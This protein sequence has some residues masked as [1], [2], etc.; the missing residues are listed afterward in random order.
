MFCFAYVCLLRVFSSRTMDMTGVKFN[1]T[2]TW[3]V[4]PLEQITSFGWYYMSHLCINQKNWLVCWAQRWEFRGMLFKCFH[5][6]SQ[7][8]RARHA[9]YRAER[10]FQFHVFACQC[11][12]LSRAGN[13]GLR[14]SLFTCRDSGRSCS[15]ARRSLSFKRTQLL[16][17]NRFPAVAFPTF[18]LAPLPCFPLRLFRNN[19]SGTRRRPVK[20]RCMES[21]LVYSA[22]CVRNH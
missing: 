10:A 2:P 3:P 16:Y 13:H 14:I 5:A 22:A 7:L 18:K 1:L 9:R 6:C 20:R 21:G 4:F 8:E 17:A 19:W 15:R 12:Q 11:L